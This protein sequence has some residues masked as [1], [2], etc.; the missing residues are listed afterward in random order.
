MSQQKPQAASHMFWF[1]VLPCVF[2]LFWASYKL[3]GVSTRPRIEKTIFVRLDEIRQAKSPGDRWQAA[4]ELSQ[5]LQK[6]IREKGLEAMDPAKKEQLFSELTDLLN[7]HATDTRLKRYLLLTLGQTGDMRALPALHTGL[8]DTD[9]EVKFFSAWGFIEV[10]NRNTA[11]ATPENLAT[12]AQW[13]HAE[14]P[15]L[16]KIGA[17]FLVQQR[18]SIYREAVKKQFGDKDP[19]VRWNAAVALA[20]VQDS[21]AA[22]I[23][24][25]IFEL[26][27]LRA[28]DFKTTKDLQQLVA[29]ATQ[30]AHKLRD[31][32]ILKKMDVLRGQAQKAIQTPEGAAILRGLATH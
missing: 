27:K 20:S 1:F 6:I 24:G 2:F 32:D 12:V 10:L 26:S 25:E 29:T 11:A 14:D 9:S 21:S 23:L 19:E 30:A 22:P 16:R 31:P 8:N 17:T 7:R 3:I 4:Y 13:L 5:E 28:V 18:D 15:A